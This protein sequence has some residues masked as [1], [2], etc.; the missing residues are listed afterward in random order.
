MKVLHLVK[1]G[2]GATWAYRQMRELVRSGVEVAVAVPGDGPM[3]ERYRQAGVRV[4]EVQLDF[5]ARRPFEL[6]GR[7][8]RLRGLVAQERPD[9][10]HS[11]FVG[12]TLMMRLALGRSGHLP[13]LFQV[14]HP[15]H[16]QH[17]PFRRLDL[18]TA[19]ASDHWIAT[20]EL[21]GKLY[22]DA[23]VDPNRVHLSYYGVDLDA[24][25]RPAPGRLRGELGLDASVPLVGMVAYMYAPKWYVG[26]RQGIKGH[27]DFIDAVAMLARSTP[28][29]RAV[30][31]GAAW[32]GAVRYEAR[33]REY[34]RRRCPE[35]LV[36]LGSRDNV[37]RLYADMN[38]AVHPSHSEN[39]G[40]AGESSL[41]EV[42][43]VATAVGGFPD[44]IESGVSGVLVPPRNPAALA[45]A[46]TVMIEDP[47][48]ARA[49]AAEAR[50]RAE[51]MLDV[52]RT[53]AE[54]ASLYERVLAGSPRGATT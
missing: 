54:I 52:R 42:P 10:V 29:I 7:L 45:A 6:I 11:H 44:I 28:R 30:I 22:R 25:R 31:V 27:E 43:T 2:V 18:A 1:T 53:A 5:P 14:P 9:L 34:G 40:A 33:V 48:R 36:F 8:R 17:R 38:V 46:I 32:A 3:A 16:M 41:A 23:G 49:M 15:L 39:V 35:H 4:H 19:G 20:C 47:E 21:T 26:Q 37:G 13:R 51:R 50:R 24:C 12:T